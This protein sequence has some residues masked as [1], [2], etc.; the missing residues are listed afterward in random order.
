MFCQV[1]NLENVGDTENVVKLEE[2]IINQ[3]F[4]LCK[5]NKMTSTVKQNL[6]EKCQFFSNKAI[7]K[8]SLNMD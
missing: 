4:S 6:S 2:L 8:Y 1:R 7:Y 5:N 3:I